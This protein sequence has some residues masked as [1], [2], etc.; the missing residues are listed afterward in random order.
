MTW[1]L[2]VV[3]AVITYSSRVA[4]VAFLPHPSPRVERIVRRIPAPLFA[5]FAANALVTVD[6]GFETPETYA[7]VGCALLVALRVRSLLVILAGGLAGYGVVA[8]ITGLL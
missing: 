4:A 8:G 7:A 6:R 5:G 2:L 3:L 1:G